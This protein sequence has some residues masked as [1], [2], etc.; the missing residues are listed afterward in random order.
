[1]QKENAHID[2]T[3][4]STLANKIATQWWPNIIKKSKQTIHYI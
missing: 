2:C 1:M 3:Q 4:I